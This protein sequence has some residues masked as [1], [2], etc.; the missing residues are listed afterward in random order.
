MKKLMII[1]AGLGL[2]AVTSQAGLTWGT[3][4]A[5]TNLNGSF[6]PTSSGSVSPYSPN[7]PTVGAFAQLIKANVTPQP[8]VNSGSGVSGGDVV[9]A[10]TYS[11]EN[12]DE[13]TAG[14]FNFQGSSI[15]N[16]SVYN[17][18]YYVR[19]FNAAQADLASWNQGTNAPIPTGASYYFQSTTLTYT[20]DPLNPVQFEF[21]PSGGQ[22]S[23]PVP[24]PT[25]MALLGIGG[26]VLARRLR[27]KG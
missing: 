21:A 17:G 20:H 9:M 26:L 1:V 27:R 6:V 4:L 15:F 8:F 12:D 11:G 14:G 24:E 13:Q 19:V 22:A 16:S 3:A 7:D 5:I 10:I 18:T 2:F 23:N 25:T